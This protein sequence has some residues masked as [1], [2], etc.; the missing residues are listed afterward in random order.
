MTFEYEKVLETIAA[1][2]A[3]H[4]ADVDRG[5]FPTETLRA[6][7]DAG[8]LGLVSATEVGGKGLGLPAASQAVERIARECA[9]TA[10]VVCMHPVRPP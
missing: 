1:T 3:Q 7:G 4:A 10:M 5:S 2:A 9:S 8:L 6:M